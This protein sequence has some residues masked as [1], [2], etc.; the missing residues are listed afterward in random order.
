M[1]LFGQYKYK[2][3]PDLL[4][5]GPEKSGFVTFWE[6]I[7]RK[8]GKMMIVN[9]IYFAVTLPIMIVPFLN[10][11]AYYNANTAAT[12]EAV[13]DIFPG[14][15]LLI[16]P[17]T[18]LP[19]AA[20]IALLALSALLYG[21]ATMGLTYVLRNFAQERHSWVSDFFSRARM[22]FRQ[23]VFFGIL[24]ILV[25]TSLANGILGNLPGFGNS[26]AIMRALC[27]V[28]LAVYWSMR[29]YFYTMAVTVNL[30]MMQI[31]RNAL[32]FVFLGFWRNLVAVGISLG[33]FFLVFLWV[34]LL[35]VVTWPL[36][37]YSFTGF[38]VIFMCYPVIDKY[39]VSKIEETN[40]S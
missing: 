39:I 18:Y 16:A 9:L 8:F 34:P 36:I 2:D 7:A 1:A 25:F 13:V 3:K 38:G 4:P 22:N 30:N 19:L 28:A 5:D 6:I 24:D 27:I 23:G 33:F 10:V 15:S 21:P 26:L 14:V 35:T 20:H 11:N 12:A 29:H 37:F 17:L 40:A 31:I 32:M